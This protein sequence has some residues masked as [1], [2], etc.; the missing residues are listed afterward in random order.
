[1]IG[2]V[3]YRKN[4]LMKFK[5]QNRQL[6]F[7]CRCLTCINSK[8]IVIIFTFLDDTTWKIV[9]G[10]TVGVSIFLLVGILI[11]FKYKHFKKK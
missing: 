7:I 6:H 2:H 11:L 8:V 9:V 3:D 4:L 10:V 1:M 5:T